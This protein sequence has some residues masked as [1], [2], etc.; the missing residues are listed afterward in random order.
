MAAELMQGKTAREGIHMSFRLKAAIA[1]PSFWGHWVAFLTG[2]FLILAGPTGPARAAQ[3]VTIEISNY[4]FAPSDVTI[5]PGTTVVWV[6]HD[7]MVH[8][9]VSTD[10]LF[11]SKA[12]DTGDQYSFTFDKEG[13][14][15]YVCSL[16]P[17][18]SGMIK[19]RRP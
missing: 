6:N 15:G 8:S 9:I 14:Y 3:T 19:V 7:D 10:R 12:M 11:D 16:H 13:D 5:A 2:T 18:M 4:N 1:T 17:Y